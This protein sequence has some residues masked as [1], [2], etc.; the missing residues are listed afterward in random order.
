MLDAATLK[1]NLDEAKAEFTEEECERLVTLIGG[2]S[3]KSIDF[4]LFRDFMR[5]EK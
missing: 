4:E 1:T 5:R 3:A 2:S